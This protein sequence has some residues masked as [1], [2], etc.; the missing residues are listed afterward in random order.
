MK[1]E[2]GT[3][4]SNELLSFFA[5]PRKFH[6]RTESCKRYLALAYHLVFFFLEMD[7]MDQL[8]EN[9]I[10]FRIYI[11]LFMFLLESLNAF[12]KI[13]VK[14]RKRFAVTARN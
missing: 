7:I 10:F 11:S 6:W 14:K 4:F 1:T 2:L 5:L 12:P 8:N 13:M 9:I 3:D